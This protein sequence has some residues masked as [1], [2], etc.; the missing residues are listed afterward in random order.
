MIEP[1]PL[2]L[3]ALS[4]LPAGV[5]R[6]GFD[7]ESARIG[8]VHLGLGGFHRAHMARYTHDLMG[9]RPDCLGWGIAGAGILPADRRMQE[10]L[11]PQDCLYTLVERQDEREY[12]TVIGSIRK[13]IFAGRSSRAVLDAIANRD[14]RIVS[15]TVTAHGYCLNPATKQLDA[16]HPS[17]VHDLA[18]PE[19]PSSAIGILVESLRRRSV[20][21][22]PAFT[23]L[24][25]DNIQHNGRVLR[26][27]VLSLA[28]L[29]DP[30]LAAWIEASASFPNTMVDRIT[31]GTTAGDITYLASRFGVA[32]RWPVFSELFSQWVIEDGFVLGRPPWEQVGA[33]FVQDVAPYEFMKLRLLNASH[34]AVAGL[35]RLA[36]Y[37]YID[38]ALRDACIHA[39]MQVLMDRE[40]GPTLPQV[41]GVDLQAYKA[42]LLVRF[43]N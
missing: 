6:P 25:C 40:T 34:L 41:P 3:G 28:R 19:Q 13:V 12:A 20:D 38:E 37:A 42:Q 14:I 23:A 35:G 16:S 36:G 33:Q 11:L 30:R 24:S 10:A 9:V 18:H 21:G 4:R 8:I 31:P 5:V 7:P 26:D 27:A 39:Y 15:L 29:R 1:V 2:S 22:L 17:I 32:D 43:G